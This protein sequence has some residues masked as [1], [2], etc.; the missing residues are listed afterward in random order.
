MGGVPYGKNMNYL[1]HLLLPSEE[2]A[3]ALQQSNT[4][5][6]KEEEKL[7]AEGKLFA[8]DE[9]LALEDREKEWAEYWF[10]AVSERGEKIR[11]RLSGK[12][13]YD[14]TAHLSVELALLTS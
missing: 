12:D 10:D 6:K 11:T 9:G 14:E 5:S 4:S 13:G 7:K 3:R 2:H 8:K 1:E